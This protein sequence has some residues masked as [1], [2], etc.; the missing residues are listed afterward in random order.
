MEGCGLTCCALQG[1]ENTF[2]AGVLISKA[3]FP[4]VWKSRGQL[5]LGQV[6]V[7]LPPDWQVG[8]AQGQTGWNTHRAASGELLVSRVEPCR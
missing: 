5:E 1:Q 8:S 7:P 6:E 3:V 2:N 4:G